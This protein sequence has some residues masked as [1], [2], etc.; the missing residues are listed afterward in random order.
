MIR[1]IAAVDSKLGISND[2]NIPW[3]GML[4]HDRAYYEEKIKT[5]DVLMGYGTYVKLSSPNPLVKNYVATLK[6][7]KLRDGFITIND[8]KAFLQNLDKNIW[9]IG[10]AVIFS[11]FLYLADELY[12]THVEKDFNCTKF[13]PE[14]DNEFKITSSSKELIEN[15]IKYRFEVWNKQ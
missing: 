13:F 2:T 9:V 12:L 3:L 6:T 5:A 11:N 10:G 8:P 4:E 15:N 1:F 7:K 14:F